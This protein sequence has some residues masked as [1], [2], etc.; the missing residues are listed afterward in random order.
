M[1]KMITKNIID[2]EEVGHLREQFT[3]RN[4]C[5]CGYVGL[6]DLPMSGYSPHLGGWKVDGGLWWLYIKCP[7]CGHC[8]SLWKLGTKRERY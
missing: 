2:E 4:V 8:W 7:D 3:K 6:H 5:F 1:I